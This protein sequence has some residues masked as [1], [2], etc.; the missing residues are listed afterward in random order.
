MFSEHDSHEILQIQWDL[1]SQVISDKK[2]MVD[3]GPHDRKKQGNPK[4]KLPKK[5]KKKNMHYT[6]ED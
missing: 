3:H 2:K 4:K 1:Q 6:P 5:K